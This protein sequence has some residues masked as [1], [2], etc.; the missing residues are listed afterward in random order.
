MHAHNQS[1]QYSTYFNNHKQYW[2]HACTH[3]YVLRPTSRKKTRRLHKRARTFILLAFFNHIH[4]N[5]LSERKDNDTSISGRLLNILSTIYD[6]VCLYVASLND[7]NKT[8]HQPG[9]LSRF[10]TSCATFI[11]PVRFYPSKFASL[12]KINVP[13]K[14][15]LKLRNYYRYPQGTR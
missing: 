15:S 4:L 10:A 14:S 5:Y 3:T 6:M 2:M 13:L 9:P 12:L 7:C 8:R 11:S 1:A